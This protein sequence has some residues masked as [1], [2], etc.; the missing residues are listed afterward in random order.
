MSRHFLLGPK[1]LFRP[2]VTFAVLAIL[3]GCSTPYLPPQGAPVARLRIAFPQQ[4]FF[5]KVYVQG[6]AAERCEN[7]MDL[8]ELG[9]KFNY[10]TPPPLMMPRI[11]QL[12][13]HAYSEHTIPVG[14]RFL[15]SATVATY[16]T[17]KITG[18]FLP[19]AANDYE[20]AVTFGGR[21]C[22]LIIRR[23][24]EDAELKL[25]RVPEPT[26]V[27]SQRCTKD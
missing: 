6:Y 26:A 27:Y 10:T 9:G 15:V 4:G 7:Q 19:I 13:E 2:A 12:N 5:A 18:S 8:G 14:Q 1:V 25:L 23:L 11:E 21:H 22:E 16:G 20:I 3:T 17:C 24:T